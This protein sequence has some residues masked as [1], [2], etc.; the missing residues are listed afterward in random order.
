MNVVAYRMDRTVF[1]R[2]D[3][4]GTGPATTGYV[5]RVTG[6]YVGSFATA[7]REMSGTVGPGTYAVSVSGTNACGEGSATAAPAVSMP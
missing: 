6:S 2:W 4:A 5:L 7:G 3:P 1:A